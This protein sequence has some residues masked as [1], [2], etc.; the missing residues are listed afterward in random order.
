M[1]S[2]V[3]VGVAVGATVAGAFGAGLEPPPEHPTPSANDAQSN[4]KSARRSS[5][6]PALFREG[7]HSYRSRATHRLA[8]VRNAWQCE[9]RSLRL[10]GLRRTQRPNVC[11]AVVSLA[12]RTRF[13]GGKFR[14]R[15]RPRRCGFSSSNARRARARRFAHLQ[16][17]RCRT[18][19]R[20]GLWTAFRQRRG[21]RHDAALLD[22]IRA[23]RRSAE[24]AVS[25]DRHPRRYLRR[26]R[27]RDRQSRRRR[28]RFRSALRW[29]AR[30]SHGVACNRTQLSRARPATRCSR[31]PRVAWCR[32][33][34]RCPS[35]R[36]RSRR[37]FAGAAASAERRRA[38]DARRFARGPTRRFCARSH[39]GTD[40]DARAAG[41]P[42]DADLA[43]GQFEPQLCAL[44]ARMAG[45]DR[46]ALC[47]R[48]C[49]GF[50]RSHPDAAAPS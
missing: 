39:R 30:E 33:A 38:H 16:R 28:A 20:A 12:P 31:F 37:S 1:G 42:R 48:A 3:A 5:M 41:R 13:D 27:R 24:P 15:D 7:R 40:G 8:H 43:A 6:R 23:R 21:A 14:A 11:H 34:R 10:R 50:V 44:S 29:L 32:G 26:R 49:A 19:R 36:A 45:R 18:G 17:L 22:G 2:G 9:R 35:V 25:R 46:R 4:R 47:N